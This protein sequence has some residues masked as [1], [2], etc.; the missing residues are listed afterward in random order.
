[1]RALSKDEVVRIAGATTLSLFLIPA[2]VFGVYEL[3]SLANSFCTRFLVFCAVITIIPALLFGIYKLFEE[4]P[5]DESFPKT[6][7]TSAITISVKIRDTSNRF[8]VRVYKQSTVKQ[9]KHAIQQ[10]KGI[11]QAKQHL[12]FSGR[13]MEDRFKLEQYSVQE[14]DTV[15][16]SFDA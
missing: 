16:M 14:N 15:M 11:S 10:E 6:E 3:F 1:M 13:W 2:F 9:L 12:F 8:D 7:S 4:A 5:I